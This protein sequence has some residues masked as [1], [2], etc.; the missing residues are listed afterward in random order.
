MDKK[1]VESHI[2]TEL[3]TAKRLSDYALGI[4][5][6]MPSNKAT[7]KAIKNGL[8][9]INGQRGYTGDFVRGGEVLVL[10]KS[11]RMLKRPEIDIKLEV[12]F[13]D[14]YLAIINKPA[15]ILVSGN[16][17]ITLENSLSSNLK[18]SDLED[19]LRYPE[20]IH[21]LDYPTSGVLLIGKTQSSVIAL[22]KLF[23]DRQIDKYYM[24]ITIG[25]MNDYGIV[26]KMIGGKNA[27]SEYWKLQSV[28]SERFGFL[29][30]VK[31][32]LYTGRRHQ[33]RIH[34]ASIGNPILGDAEY[35]IESKILKGKGLYL[36]SNILDFKHPFK[37]E[38]V[39]I[40]MKL[41]AKFL[42]IFPAEG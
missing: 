37:N 36:Q 22:N 29:N 15:G 7:K 20:P 10:Q 16:K 5:S 41:P 17:K 34:M 11:F 26:E 19:A 28:I 25:S 31:M 33:L 23:E 2:V 42:K 18:T 24:A 21:R 3:K 27:K 13:E 30:L 6:S 39:K 14:E 4:F 1:Q 38:Q 8:V 12:L 35:G 9:L 40:E 32:K